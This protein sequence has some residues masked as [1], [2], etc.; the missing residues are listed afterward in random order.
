MTTTGAGAFPGTAARSGP[1][2]ASALLGVLLVAGALWLLNVFGRTLPTPA[3]A[4]AWAAAAAAIGASFFRRARLRR[5]ALLAGYLRR[6][7]PLH[8]RLRGGPLMAARSALAGAAVALVLLV[9]AVRLEDRAAWVVLIASAPLLVAAYAASSRVLAPHA[10]EAYRRELAWRAA[11]ALV[12]AAMVAALV[13]LA[14]HRAYPDLGQA[15]LEQAVWHF[16]DAEHARSAPAA[17]LLDAAAAKDGLRLWLAQQLLPAPGASLAEAAGWLIVLAE[18]A[19][20][21]WSYLSLCS[22]VL[23][24]IHRH[25][26]DRADRS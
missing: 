18:E 9:A 20:F 7:S 10:A 8:E 16:V 12:G 17:A 24:G 13:A 14:F 5:A 11:A 26:R 3:L 2:A 23:S 1:S 4:A 22:V 19:L 21:V 25:D 15:T 6:E